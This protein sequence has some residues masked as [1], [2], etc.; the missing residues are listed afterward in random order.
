MPSSLLFQLI[1]LTS[2]SVT[3][4]LLALAL[5]RMREEEAP[6]ERVS[7]EEMVRRMP[8]DRIDLAINAG[9]EKLLRKTKVAIMRADNFVTDKLNLV[10]ADTARKGNGNGNGSGHGNGNGGG[11]GSGDYI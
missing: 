2:A 4:Y 11:E 7:L 10:R 5:P 6:S 3:L 1:L 9:L 8:L